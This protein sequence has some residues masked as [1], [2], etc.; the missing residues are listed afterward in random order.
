MGLVRKE[1]SMSEVLTE[2]PDTGTKV[3]APPEKPA[4]PK[5]PEL[6]RAAEIVRERWCQHGYGGGPDTRDINTR[7]AGNA[8]LEAEGRFQNGSPGWTDGQR[9]FSR[10]MGWGKY[11]A[12]EM[13]F[14]NDT[15]GRTREEV[16]EALERAA[17]GL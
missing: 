17:W 4:E 13:F 10:A 12:R 15:P 14:W 5:Y 6:L 7:C 3:Q 8:I 9:R 16:A 11:G 1:I 2:S